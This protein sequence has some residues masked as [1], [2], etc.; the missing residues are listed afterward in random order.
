MHRGLVPAVR[1]PM[2]RSGYAMEPTQ[3]KPPRKRRRWLIVAFVFVS[4]SLGTWWYWPRGDARFVGTWQTSPGYS[5]TFH[6]NGTGTSNAGHQPRVKWIWSVDGSTLT[7]RYN[8]FLERVPD[9]LVQFLERVLG[10]QI[11]SLVP[12]EGYD[13]LSV[14]SN[15]LVV[16]S[17]L[18]SKRS[19]GFVWRKVI[20]E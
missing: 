17:H 11:R 4:V 1:S 14:D 12:I 20:P 15:Q 10:R 13:I 8:P 3:G 16:K 9:K 6:A 7:I 18:S 19:K 5:Y 2:T